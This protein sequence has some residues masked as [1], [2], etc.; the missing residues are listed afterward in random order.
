MTIPFRTLERRRFWERE[1]DERLGGAVRLPAVTVSRPPRP[2]LSGTLPTARVTAPPPDDDGNFIASA[3]R[4]AKAQEAAGVP[5]AERAR[6]TAAFDHQPG[7][8][9][10]LLDIAAGNLIA[11]LSPRAADLATDASLERFT[12]GGGDASKWATPFGVAAAAGDVLGNLAVSRGVTV[13]TVATSAPLTTRVAS[14]AAAGAIEN[15]TVAGAGAAAFGVGADGSRD[16]MDVLREIATSAAAGAAFGGVMEG[17]VGKMRGVPDDSPELAP[18]RTT[19]EATRGRVF[20]RPDT[21]E[22][23]TGRAGIVRLERDPLP[24]GMEPQGTAYK[25]PIDD[26]ADPRLANFK[27]LNL[28]PDAETKIREA[29]TRLDLS[30]RTVTW[31]ETKAAAD[32][33]G[34]NPARLLNKDGRLRGDELLA[35]RDVISQNAQR[36]VDLSAERAAATTDDAREAAQQA[37][38]RLSEETDQYL[39][40]YS[41]E[42]TRAGRDLN[43]LRIVARNSMAP[44]VWLA[45]AQ[46]VK[47]DL[48]LASDEAAEVS[49][50]ALSNDREGL[51]RFVS[52]LH[53]SSGT[54][55]ALAIWKAGLLTNPLTHLKNTAGNALMGAAETAKEIPAAAIDAVISAV[56]G[57]ER[58]KAVSARGLLTEQVR[59]LSAGAKAAMRVLKYGPEPEQLSRWDFRR[60]NFGPT[61]AGRL[62]QAYT[63]GVFHA[64]AAQDALFKSAALGRAVE[65]YARLE[66]R[67]MVKR[68]AAPT[69]DAALATLRQDFPAELMVKAIADAEVATFQ[70]ENVLASGFRGMKAGLRGNGALG[71]GAAAAADVVVPFVKTPTNVA[72]TLV[73]YSPVGLVSALVK[74]VGDPSQKRLAEDLGR[75]LTGSTLVAL[76]FML[77]R[78]GKAT[79]AAPA[80]PSDRA[81]WDLENKSANSVRI[82]ERWHNVSTLSPVGAL[83]AVGAQMYEASTEAG[84]PV[85]RAAAAAFTPAKVAL[86]QSF[87]KGV[88]GALNAVNDP[89]RYGEN[90]AESTAGSV[91][92]AAV[93][94]IARGTDP[95]IRDAQGPMARIQARLPGLSR[96]VPPRMTAFGEPMRANG[97]ILAQALDVTQS[98]RSTDTPLL[99]EM[100][101]LD[102]TVGFP[103][104]TRTVGGLRERRTDDDYRALLERIG[105][106]TKAKLEAKV[107]SS[108]WGLIDDEAKRERLEEIV[109]KVRSAEYRTERLALKRAR[110]AQPS[111]ATR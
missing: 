4:R 75:S 87:L 62:A 71:R 16:P 30:K 12:A 70:Q 15:A 101:R 95:L 77:A 18:A 50:L 52:G 111:T 41:T 13:P 90:F 110:R 106:A 91:V 107:A 55:K 60:T 1:P 49:R 105:P 40:R 69:L 99:A 45:Q 85:G 25:A 34:I 104:R 82:G 56:R 7:G 84:S 3:F 108:G 20:V 76:G 42:R 8:L 24:A 102:L 21:P 92:P 97:G 32:E 53:K 38:A 39:K 43:A 66:A 6:E 5:P 65:E 80:N 83:V 29:Y 46:R 64:L 14:R 100:R 48:P 37:I 44:A 86:D 57:T 11:P 109:S 96:N 67:Q 22:P 51:I 26:G 63:D 68:G 79:G 78:E 89:A 23:T 94:M 47:A 54:D 33:L 9:E 88:S 10:T 61:A 103:S 98:R 17:V 27:K 59:G 31:E 74:Q 2:A 72:G 28:S 73:Q 93:A 19:G 58:T 81:Q 35:V 36:M